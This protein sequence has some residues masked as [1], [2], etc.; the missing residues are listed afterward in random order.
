M[1]EPSTLQLVLIFG[2]VLCGM[3][4]MVVGLLAMAWLMG[5]SS[6]GQEKAIQAS[7]NGAAQALGL[8]AQAQGS[9]PPRLTGVVGGRPVQVAGGYGSRNSS[10]Y[11]SV[12]IR[13]NLPAGVKLVAG[14]RQVWRPGEWLAAGDAELDKE[15]QF[16]SEPPELLAQVVAQPAVRQLLLEMRPVNLTI[17]AQELHC[18]LKGVEADANRLRLL[19]ELAS[20]TASAV[21]QQMRA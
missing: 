9:R 5:R 10:P 16:Q 6:A 14:R 19:V 15:Y 11:T 3:G 4:A 7:W 18:V 20:A 12:A 8:A 13:T 1:E 2:G 21:A 17:T